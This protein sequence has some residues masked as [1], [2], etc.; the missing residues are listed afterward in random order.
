MMKQH[1]GQIK[2]FMLSLFHVASKH[3]I[4]VSL[5]QGQNVIFM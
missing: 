5:V 4:F 3:K 1:V 2:Y